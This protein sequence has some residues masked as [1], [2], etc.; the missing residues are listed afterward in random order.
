MSSAPAR[1]TSQ[2]DHRHRYRAAGVTDRLRLRLVALFKRQPSL[3][4]SCLGFRPTF[5]VAQ[6]PVSLYKLYLRARIAVSLY[7]R[8]GLFRPLVDLRSEDGSPALPLAVGPICFFATCL[9]K[10][11]PRTMF[12][13]RSFGG[14]PNDPRCYRR[15]RSHR[16]DL[17]VCRDDRDL[18]ARFRCSLR[19]RTAGDSRLPPRCRALPLGPAPPPS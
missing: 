7:V 1:S 14:H 13:L 2:A 12:L 3:D 18:G 10:N 8:G 11:K 17:P 5:A 4:G 6:Y 19:V 9:T 16:V 15:G